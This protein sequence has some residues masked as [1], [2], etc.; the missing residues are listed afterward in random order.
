[1]EDCMNEKTLTSLAMTCTMAIVSGQPTVTL[2]AT[3]KRPSG[4]PVGSLLS[5][6]SNGSKNYA[7]NPVK[8]LAW[9]HRKTTT[10][11]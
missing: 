4:F 10:A 5:I 8:V 3:G 6:G 9:I 1:M 2:S 11:A 7:V